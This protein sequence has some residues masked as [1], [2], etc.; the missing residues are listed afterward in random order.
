MTI[1]SKVKQLV[2]KVPLGE[3]DEW[4]EYF[5]AQAYIAS[6]R[7]TCGSRRV[8]AVI[9]DSLESGYRRILATGYNG[10]PPGDKHC[11][12]GGCPRFKARLD[13]KIKSG[14]YNDNFPCFA[15]HAEANALFQM[16]QR[17]ISTKD[18][19]LFSTAFP[20]RACSE[21]ILG[22]GIKEIYYSE[23]YPDEY[24]KMY[25]NKYGIK[26]TKVEVEK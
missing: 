4:L 6:L 11:V 18:C 26:H 21:K 3:R 8:G 22:S 19:I 5:M 13:G 10:N 20:C 9:V 16:S 12:D 1:L 24:S 7:S 23:G 15:F 25:L 17:G 14:E 2:E